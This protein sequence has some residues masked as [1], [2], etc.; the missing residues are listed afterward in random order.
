MNL[1]RSRVEPQTI[2]RETAQKTNWKKK[3]AAPLPPSEPS[4]SDPLEMVSPKFRKKPE[5]PAS[6][7]PPPNA[8]AKPQAHHTMDEIEKF[9]RIFATIVPTFLPGVTPS[10][11]KRRPP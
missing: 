10:P 2:A 11:R 8:M 9:V 3:N 6:L 5:S 1:I 7:A 4:T